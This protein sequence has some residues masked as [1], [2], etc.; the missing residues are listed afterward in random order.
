ML[1][2]VGGIRF[3]AARKAW[4]NIGDTEK[5]L[6]KNS[7]VSLSSRS[8]V[9]GVLLVF[10]IIFKLAIA[11]PVFKLMFLKLKGRVKCKIA[12]PIP[13]LNSCSQ[14]LVLVTPLKWLVY[15]TYNLSHQTQ[16]LYLYLNYP[17]SVKITWQHW[18]FPLPWNFFLFSWFLWPLWYLDFLPS[19]S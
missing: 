10:S 8:G 1:F 17:W 18:T 6:A 7:E 12:V 15:I 4:L 14:V 16:Y 11:A 13:S 9:S 3:S 2:G 19:Q 5:Q